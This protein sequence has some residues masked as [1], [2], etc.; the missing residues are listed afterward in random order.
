[1][2][3]LTFTVTGA[4][5][6]LVGEPFAPRPLYFVVDVAAFGANNTVLTG[7]IGAVLRE[8]QTAVPEPA[9]WSLM[10]LGF[11]GVGALLRKRR[12]QVRPILA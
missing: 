8:S 1:M 11:G 9:T 5:P 7:N 10:I 6:V 4:S 2:N 12:T 3:T